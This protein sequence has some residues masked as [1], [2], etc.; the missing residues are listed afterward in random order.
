MEL[1]TETYIALSSVCT[2]F[3]SIWRSY[4]QGPNKGRGTVG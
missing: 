2:I 4:D 1:N 3:A